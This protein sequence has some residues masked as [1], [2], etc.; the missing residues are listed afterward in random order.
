MS[1]TLTISGKHLKSIFGAFYAHSRAGIRAK[2]SS[3]VIFDPKFVI[4]APKLVKE[5]YRII[6]KVILV[7][8]W[9]F[10]L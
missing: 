9:N 10:L 6:E 7:N 2:T 8:F 5:D 1:N 4:Y 3:Q